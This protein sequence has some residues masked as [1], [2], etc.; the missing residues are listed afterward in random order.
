MERYADLRRRMRPPYGGGLIGDIDTLIAATV[1][2]HDL[3]LVTMDRHFERVPALKLRL[4]P[5]ASN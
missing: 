2:E 3:T 5:R 4:L 1:M